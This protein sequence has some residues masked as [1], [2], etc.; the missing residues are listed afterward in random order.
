MPGCCPPRTALGSSNVHPLYPQ[1]AEGTGLK[2]VPAQLDAIAGR[3]DATASPRAISAWRG[4]VTEHRRR[5]EWLAIGL[6]HNGSH[7]F[8][9]LPFD[10]A[11]RLAALVGTGQL[12]WT[13][14]N[15]ALDAKI[16]AQY[17]ERAGQA[18]EQYLGNWFTSGGDEFVYY[19]HV[20]RYSRHGFWGLTEDLDNPDTPKMRAVVRVAEE[21][22]MSDEGQD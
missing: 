13:E 15:T 21:F 18:V 2:S 3:G 6:P 1:A 22:R 5:K 9:R 11:I 7:L 14:V 8:A 19:N 12:T 20:S 10:D 17:D 4:A 16:R